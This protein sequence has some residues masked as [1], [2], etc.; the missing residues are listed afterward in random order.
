[1]NSVP[2]PISPPPSRQNF[3][4]WFFKGII[5]LG[6]VER[7]IPVIHAGPERKFLVNSLFPG[8]DC[9]FWAEFGDFWVEFKKFPVNFAVLVNE[10]G[11]AG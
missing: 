4:G 7:R 6:E 5:S 2:R 11:N 9:I 3:A 1:L 8:Q 10:D